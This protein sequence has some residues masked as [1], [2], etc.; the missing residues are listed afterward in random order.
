[1]I[2]KFSQNNFCIHCVYDEN[3][4]RNNPGLFRKLNRYGDKWYNGFRV[5]SL[6]RQNDQYRKVHVTQKLYDHITTIQRKIRSRTIHDQLAT[7]YLIENAE[8]LAVVMHQVENTIIE[9]CERTMNKDFLRTTQTFMLNYC[10]NNMA[11]SFN[12]ISKFNNIIENYLGVKVGLRH[13]T[14]A[15][16]S[17]NTTFIGTYLQLALARILVNMKRPFSITIDAATSYMVNHFHSLIMFVKI[18]D[19]E[20]GDL[21]GGRPLLLDNIDIKGERTAE[22]Y[23]LHIVTKHVDVIDK[24]VPGYKEF[25]KNYLASVNSDR[26]ATM[27]LV[28]TKLQQFKVSDGFVPAV[29]RIIW[30]PCVTHGLEVGFEIALSN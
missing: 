28:A 30:I 22:N 1:M 25:W 26:A 2:S 5:Q 8:D 21:L 14:V 27:E 9:H 4:E 7:H 17:S 6:A 11:I 16:I 15:S 18:F 24:V 10:G 20:A 23:K 29:P 12:S 13:R 3:F 19:K